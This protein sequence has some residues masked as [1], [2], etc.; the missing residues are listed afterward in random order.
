MTHDP[1]TKPARRAALAVMT[2]LGAYFL[3]ATPVLVL[4]GFQGLAFL[5]PLIAALAAGRYAWVHADD[6][7]RYLVAF[8]FYGAVLFGGAGFAAGFFGPMIFTPEANQGPLLGLLITG[9]AGV[10]IGAI[11]GLMYGLVKSRRGVHRHTTPP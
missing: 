5:I 1:A 4:F 7:P 11:S 2:F 3:T 8:V 6:M 10:L 9:P